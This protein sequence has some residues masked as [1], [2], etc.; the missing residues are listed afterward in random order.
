[1]R[2]S[3]CDSVNSEPYIVSVRM[4]VP[5]LASHSW[6]RIWEL[7]HAA[8]R[9]VGCR[10]GS[11]PELLWLWGR[12][13]AAAQI[14]LLAWEIPYA[15]GVAIKKKKKKSW[16]N[17]RILICSYYSEEAAVSWLMK[18]KWQKICLR[19]FLH[20]FVRKTERVKIPRAWQ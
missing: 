8:C 18:L 17:N 13:A 1:M 15:T 9:G 11:D 19:C 5:S 3:C 7:P 2:S 20:G 14:R 4:Q 6:L 10:C 16:L 12:P